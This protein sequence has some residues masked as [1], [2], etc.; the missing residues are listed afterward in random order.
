MIV[1]G[2]VL[3]QSISIVKSKNIEVEMNIKPPVAKK[4]KHITNIH[5]TELVD[6]Y[7]WLRADNWPEKITDEEVLGYAKAEN[8]YF[9]HYIKQNDK[10][11]NE[12]FEELK[13]RIKLADQSAYVKKDDYYYYSRTEEDKEYGIYCRKKGSTEAKEEILLNINELAKDK[14]YIDI[15]AFSVSPNHKLIAYS[16]DLTGGEKYTIVVF[17]LEKQKML[18]DQIPDTIGGVTWHEDNTGFFYTPTDENWRHDKVMYHKLGSDY[19]EDKL[20]LH[21]ANNLYSVSAGKSSSREYI[22]INV[23]GHDNNE[24]YLIKM[25]DPSFTPILI[26][27]KQEKILYSVDHGFTPGEDGSNDSKSGHGYFYV[28]TNDGEADNFKVLRISDEVTSKDN[29]PDDAG[30]K[31][32]TTTLSSFD[33][34]WEEYIAEDEAKDLAGLSLAE[35]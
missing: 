24:E 29:I 34:N 9:E 11:K 23:S 19:K 1:A 18:T 8:A 20:I 33:D 17:D 12:L 16:T 15:G 2:I 6:E 35:G 5:G 21:E 27:P 10:L 13:G 31:K 7:H 26:K 22:F 3:L 30:R 14:K 4:E 28:H 32:V 25:S